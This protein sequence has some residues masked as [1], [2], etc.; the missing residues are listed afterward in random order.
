FTRQ[1]KAQGE[2]PAFDKQEAARYNP[3]LKFQAKIHNVSRQA[4]GP[5]LKPGP[6]IFPAAKLFRFKESTEREE[7]F[8]AFIHPGDFL[9][10]RLDFYIPRATNPDRGNIFA[11]SARS[12][13]RD[14]HLRARREQ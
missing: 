9:R 11:A 5:A 4:H 7:N 6:L 2:C 10:R 1:I 13:E 3:P 12:A 8:S 14:R